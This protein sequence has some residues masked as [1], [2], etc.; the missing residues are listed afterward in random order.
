MPHSNTLWNQEIRAISYFNSVR[1]VHDYQVQ[2][3]FWTIG[4]S[5]SQLITFRT[6]AYWRLRGSYE[7][8]VLMTSAGDP[9]H[10]CQGPGHQTGDIYSPI[11]GLQIFILVVLWHRIYFRTPLPSGFSTPG[12]LCVPRW[13]TFTVNLKKPPRA[14]FWT[15]CWKITQLI[16]SHSRRVSEQNR[17][18]PTPHL[19]LPK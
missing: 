12:G 5:I 7:E 16:S 14:F 9:L 15:N 6:L 8:I 11:W 2:S 4:K 10:T 3:H 13:A 1:W 17:L 19:L 18:A